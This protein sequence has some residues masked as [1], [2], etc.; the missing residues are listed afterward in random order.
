MNHKTVASK[1]GKSTALKYGNEY[2]KELARKSWAK[3][4]LKYGPDQMATVR[5]GQK[6]KESLS[7]E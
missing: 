7:L 4:L 3:R 2:F 5:R 6:V 1:G